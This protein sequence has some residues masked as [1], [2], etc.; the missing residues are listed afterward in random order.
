MTK[1]EEDSYGEFMNTYRDDENNVKYEMAPCA[2]HSVSLEKKRRWLNRD[3][4]SETVHNI[5]QRNIAINENDNEKVINKNTN[6]AQIPTSYDKENKS[7]KA[8]TMEMLMIDGD[9]STTEADEKERI[10]ESNKKF[11]Y[12]RAIHSNHMI[13]HHM[14][15]IVICERV[16]YEYR[17][18]TDEER[19]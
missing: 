11:L 12:A 7:L 14:Q 13:Q 18:L 16:V 6:T 1:Y 2:Q 19:D 3:I 8:W 5:N 10:E 4:P 17:S 15:Q 9:I